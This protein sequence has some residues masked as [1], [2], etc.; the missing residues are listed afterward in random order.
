MSTA[1]ATV[2]HVV[3]KT[4]EEVRF[5][6]NEKPVATFVDDKIVITTQASQVEY[7]FNSVSYFDFEENTSG[8][9]KVKVDKVTADVAI[10]A[11]QV[12]IS[13]ALA[14]SPV[15]IF[16][17]NGTTHGTYKVADDGTVSFS[18]AGLPQGIYIIKGNNI[19]IKFIKQ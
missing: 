14:G 11:G 12:A 13:G 1:F 2:L 16:G 10:K 18:T 6:F 3:Q 8:I 19:S 5:S 15:Y 7:D 17:I 4:G 9:D